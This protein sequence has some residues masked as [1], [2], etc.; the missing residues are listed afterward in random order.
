MT[1]TVLMTADT[2]GGV[3]TYALDVARALQPLE[4]NVALATMGAP[5]SGDQAAEAAS[6]P[7]LEVVESDFKLEWMDDAWEDVDEAGDW[8]MKLE[9]HF[10]PEVI[11]LNGYAH[12][13]LPW[14]APVLTVCHSCVLSWW[15]AVKGEKAPSKWNDYAHRVRA[16]LQAS[17]LVLA[18]SWTM[19]AE[20]DRFYGPFQWA[21]VVP[22]ARRGDLFSPLFK[23][24]FVF[25]AGRVWDEAKNVSTLKK[26]AA[27]L[28]CPVFLAG[29]GGDR[30]RNVVQLG[31]LS[32]EELACWLG[33]ASIYAL[34][35]RY[36]PFGL[37]V[38]EAAMSGC[39]LV[40]GDISSLREN[41]ADAA[42]F[43]DPNDSEGLH[44]EL[45]RLLANPKEAEQLGK[46]ALE[47]SARFDLTCMGERYLELYDE[48]SVRRRDMTSLSERVMVI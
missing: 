16:G 45:R 8:L 33:R 29:E 9:Q 41:W 47:R 31:R 25:S 2:V 46:L 42:V 5:V 35:A 11:H 30:H 15:E 44:R 18:P 43:V 36:E 22:N 27:G 32:T 1:R 23:E 19:L 12:G 13:S 24:G 26:A 7:N 38:L 10:R 4:V 6:I 17:D 14:S 21:E 37:S 28:P 3:W 34:P 40:L 48:L 20:A 39:A